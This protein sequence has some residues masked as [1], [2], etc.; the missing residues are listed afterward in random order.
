M[1]QP[2]QTPDDF[3]RLRA[4]VRRHRRVYEANYRDLRNRLFAHKKVS[5]QADIDALFAKTNIQE[6]KEI[7]AFLGKLYEALWQLFFNGRK[8]VLRPSP[9]AVQ[10]RIT[11]EA[12]QFLR[13][14]AGVPKQRLPEDAPRSGR[15]D[16]LR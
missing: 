8:P 3:R 6:L 7:L 15:A 2:L 9:P 1:Y 11:H 16:N 4:D 12:E 13:S 5:A 10:E 14:I